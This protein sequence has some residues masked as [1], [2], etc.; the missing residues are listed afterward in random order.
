M[1][2]P[3]LLM[4]AMLRAGASFA[5]MLVALMLVTFLIGKAA[6]ID[7]VIKVVGDRASAEAYQA[8]KVEL[9]LDRPLPEQFLR[10]MGQVVRGDLGQSTSTGRPVVQDLATYFPATIELRRPVRLL[11]AGVLAGARRAC[12]SSTASW[13][14]YRARPA[15]RVLQRHRHHPDRRHPHRRRHRGELGGS[16]ATPSAT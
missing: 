5:L 13:A 4:R 7:P 3:L 9:G 12:S 8:A 15:R 14:G 16:S 10:Y 11:G 2:M 6:P 1:A